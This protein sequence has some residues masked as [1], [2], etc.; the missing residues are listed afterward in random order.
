MNG[1]GFCRH[2]CDHRALQR[3]GA[4]CH[5]GTAQNPVWYCSH[6]HT[7]EILDEEG[8]ES[9]C[10]VEFIKPATWIPGA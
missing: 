2:S 5:E 1:G 7:G 4:P 3:A 6:Q 9:H 8:S 10:R